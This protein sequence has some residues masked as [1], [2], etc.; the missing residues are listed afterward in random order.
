MLAL[1][2]TH[3]SN[4]NDEQGTPNYPPPPNFPP[5]AG[6]GPP[7][8]Y[9]APPPAGG[10]TGSFN[11]QDFINRAQAVITKPSIASFDAQ[12]GAANWNTIAI[13]L[14]IAGA[15]SGVF[16]GLAARNLFSGLVGGIFGIFI[17]GAIGVGILYLIARA[18]GGTGTFLNYAWAL[19]LFEAPLFAATGVLSIVP[20]LGYIASLALGIYGLYLAILATASVHRLTMGKSVAVVLI[21]AAIGAVLAICAIVAVGAALVGSGVLSR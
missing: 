8:G 10:P 1:R 2:T 14:A 17:G 7:P 9:Q 15:I 16:N 18:F 4:P 13:V 21:P 12:A 3:M 6:Y 19:T 11:F 5:P 20:F